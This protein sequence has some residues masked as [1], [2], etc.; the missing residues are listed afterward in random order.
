VIVM[1]G[2]GSLHEAYARDRDFELWLCY[3]GSDP[4][5]AERFRKTCDRLWQMTGEKWSLMRQL[6]ARARE[7][8]L[9][10]FSA[11]DYVF[12]PDDD[13][14]IPGGA[15]AVSQL[16]ALARAVDAD[17]VQP[18]IANEHVSPGHEPTRRQTTSLMRATTLVEI[19]MPAYAGRIVEGC[20]LPILHLQPHVRA[21]WGLEP[22]LQRMTEALFGR[23]PRTFVIDAVEAHHTRPT[24][25]GSAS[26]AIGWDEA[27]MNP[28]AGAMRIVELARF[29]STADAA[30]FTFPPADTHLDRTYLAR[31]LTDVRLA[32]LILAALGKN[33]P[34]ARALRQLVQQ[35]IRE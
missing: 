29:K 30:A 14:L 3:W 20:L 8:R 25:Q 11:Y 10:P 1:V 33:T 22:M 17:I 27:F 31:H 12:L 32:R 18:A 7:E 23:S 4:A 6:G 13:I 9:P 19:M 2:D 15:A 24:G 28:L 35:A 21:G 5:T 34:T 26:H 16:L